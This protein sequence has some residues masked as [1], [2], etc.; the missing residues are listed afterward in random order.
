MKTRFLV[1][2]YS[3]LVH[4]HNLFNYIVVTNPF[5]IVH[6]FLR[7]T[8]KHDVT[9]Y[10]LAWKTTIQ[11]FDIQQL[12]WTW[13][14]WPFV[15]F[16]E[17]SSRIVWNIKQYTFSI[18]LGDNEYNSTSLILD[19]CSQ[20]EPIHNFL[21]EYFYCNT[22]SV[23]KFINQLTRHWWGG[24]GGLS[25]VYILSSAYRILDVDRER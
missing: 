3:F 16:E 19:R 25:A 4:E 11:Y 12:T 7:R 22:K 13:F 21:Y 9:L 5:W 17:L 8:L 1:V 18:E 23:S 24:G 6:L 20:V 15:V 10:L 14:H 2:K